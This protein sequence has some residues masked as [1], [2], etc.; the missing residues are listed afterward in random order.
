M[1]PVNKTILN[2]DKFQIILNKTLQKRKNTS[3]FRE[4]IAF[5]SRVSERK[6]Y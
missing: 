4:N 6:L 3:P 5:T 1:L 2:I